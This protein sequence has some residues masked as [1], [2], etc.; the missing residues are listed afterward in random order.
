MKDIVRIDHLPSVAQSELFEA[1]RILLV[2]KENKQLYSTIQLI[3]ITVAPFVRM[4][5]ERKLRLLFCVSCTA[6]I[7]LLRVFTH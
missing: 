4:S 5:A 2:R 7:R 6:R 1:T 3:F